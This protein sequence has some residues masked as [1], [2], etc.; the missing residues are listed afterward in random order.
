MTSILFVGFPHSKTLNKVPNLISTLFF[1]LMTGL[2]HQI[3]KI[4]T[5]QRHARACYCDVTFYLA[6]IVQL[7]HGTRGEIRPKMYPYM[8]LGP[9]NRQERHLDFLE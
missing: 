5:S 2:W 1:F 6:G 8:I 3:K 4:S 7:Q 9:S